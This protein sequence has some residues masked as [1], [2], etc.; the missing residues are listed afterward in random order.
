MTNNAVTKIKEVAPTALTPMD[1]IHTALDKGLAI[2]K[3]LDMQERWE[4][5]EAKKAFTAAMT[6]FKADPPELTKNKTVGFGKTSFKHVSL[7]QICD[8]VGGALSAHNLSH[9]WDIK[10][11]DG[12]ISVSCIITHELGHSVST[13]MQASSDTSGSK[14][15]IQ[16]MGST[17]TYLQRYTLLA[18]TGL[19]A[20]DQDDD[21]NGF[22]GAHG[23]INEMQL[24]D[25]EGQ[26][27]KMG[28]SQAEV[29]GFK[30]YMGIAEIKDI[31][32]NDYPKAVQA[33]AKKKA[34]KK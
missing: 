21:G 19:A 7:D 17:V 10:Q 4:A 23:P 27:K 30:T 33:L 28:M 14:N 5:N 3:L 9:R 20:K 18:A 2:D 8:V 16:A 6:A 12:L 34:Q 15:I 13:S 31:R 24:A 32:V 22:G 25:I 29:D 1:M 11:A 26:I